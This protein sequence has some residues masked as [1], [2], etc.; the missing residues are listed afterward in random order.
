VLVQEKLGWLFEAMREYPLHSE[1]LECVVANLRV[2]YV[3]EI[4]GRVVW[5]SRVPTRDI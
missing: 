5:R 2:N 4:G 3:S 1:D